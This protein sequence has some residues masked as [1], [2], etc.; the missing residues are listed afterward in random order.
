[1]H[2]HEPPSALYPLQCRVST[3][4]FCFL[5]MQPGNTNTSSCFGCTAADRMPPLWHHANLIR[6]SCRPDSIVRVRFIVNKSIWGWCH[7]FFCS[8]IMPRSHIARPWASENRLAVLNVGG[9]ESEAC[10]LSVCPFE[11][12]STHVFGL[13]CGCHFSLGKVHLSWLRLCPL[14]HTERKWIGGECWFRG[15]ITYV[16][17]SVFTS[18]W[19]VEANKSSVAGLSGLRTA[20]TLTCHGVYLHCVPPQIKQCVVN[21]D[22]IHWNSS[23]S[24]R[25]IMGNQPEKVTV[26][27]FNFCFLW[28]FHLHKHFHQP[29][30]SF[31][32]C[33]LLGD[34][35]VFTKYMLDE[36]ETV[37]MCHCL[38]DTLSVDEAQRNIDFTTVLFCLF[39]SKGELQGRWKWM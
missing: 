31:Q 16:V 21:T 17:Q 33:V 4:H 22:Q 10:G 32:T 30:P 38:W 29:R 7:F 36:N 26:G 2:I 9:E 11:V 27:E 12:S 1:M 25:P 13:S 6:P 34:C 19:W 35:A 39:R 20:G 18:A 8:A 23:A 3:F 24:Q 5:G 15:R 37:V 14:A 28:C